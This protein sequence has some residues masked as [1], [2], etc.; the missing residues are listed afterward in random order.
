MIMLYDDLEKVKCVI[1]V[2]STLPR[3]VLA[4]GFEDSKDIYLL[5]M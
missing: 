4:A 3:T 2:T 1:H 5:Y